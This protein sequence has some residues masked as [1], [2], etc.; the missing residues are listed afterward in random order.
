MRLF[1][2]GAVAAIVGLTLLPGEAQPPKPPVFPAINPSA[3]RLEQT[4]NGLDGPG[5]AL[6]Y[7]ESAETL[8]AGCDRGTIQVWN[9][10]VLLNI[11]A[12]SG[13]ANVAREHDGA[14]LAAVW[15]GGIGFITAGLDRKLIFWGV[16]ETKSVMP[17]DS[18]FLVRALAMSPDKKTVAAAGEDRIIQLW[19]LDRAA[20][21][22]KLAD[23]A[24]WVIAL[25][26]SPDGKLLASGDYSGKV[27]LWEMPGGKKLTNVPA[28]PMPPPKEPPERIPATA[29]AFSP[30]SK[31]LALGLASGVIHLINPADGKILRSMT[32]HAS[33]VTGLAFHPSGGV[34]ASS[35]KD[36]TV[37]LW[38]PANAQPFKVLEGHTAWVEG[39][40]F[41]L[42]G[43]RLASVGADQTVR[44][45]DLLD[46]PKK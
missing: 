46:P 45:W 13:S 33:A 43:T 9:K 24:D 22:T 1:L 36:R 39:L 41:I 30:D 11:R 10:D 3:A 35:S 34:L 18:G 6:A 23:H 16:S 4:I 7:S 20:P 25:A 42:Q 12:G 44:I 17:V 8:L 29:L 40:V 2:S 14:V 37:R 5:F 15:T 38:N 21:T 28:P 32:G 26:Y 27:T 19:D 31:T